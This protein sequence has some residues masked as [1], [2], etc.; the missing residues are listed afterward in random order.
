MMIE[1]N[2]FIPLSHMRCQLS[3]IVSS[4]TVYRCLKSLR[5]SY[6]AT[7]RTRKG[8]AVD[9]THPFF[10][11]S[12]PFDDD[13]IAVDEASYVSCDTPRRGWSRKGHTLHKHPPKRRRVVSLL[14][15]IDRRGVVDHEITKGSFNQH[16]LAR[17][18]GR[19]PK[20]KTVVLDN[21]SLHKTATVKQ[22]CTENNIQL[23]FTPPYCPWFNPTEYAFSLSKR[24]FR[25]R[26]GLRPEGA[27]HFENDIR[28]SL[29][30]ITSAKCISFYEHALRLSR[31]HV[32]NDRHTQII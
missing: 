26:R 5:M 32:T 16:S 11:Y 18:I 9:L 28:E 27:P 13:T 3:T 30:T 31:R 7:C 10:R 8:Q 15:A 29:R 2:P 19:L 17:F 1:E 24:D 6:K 23:R 14:L 21:V 20:H 4:S 25:R 12:V 22:A